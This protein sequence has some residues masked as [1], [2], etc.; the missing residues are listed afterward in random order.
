MIKALTTDWQDGASAGFTLIEMLAVLVI[1]ALTAAAAMPLLLSG[2]GTVSLDAATIELAAALRATRAAAIVQN[3]VM[4]LSVDVDRRTFGSD[5]VGSRAFAPGIQAKLTYAAATRSGPAVGGF[6]FFPDGSSTGG[7]L[8]LELH[9][10][11]VR[12]CVD[13]L[14]GT[15]RTAAAC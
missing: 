12:L 6:R 8:S 9:G 3:R 11:Q 7:D 5:V 2:A 4:T 15:V 1:L 13:W 14:T 10:R